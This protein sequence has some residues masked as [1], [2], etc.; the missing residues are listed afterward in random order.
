MPG[1]AVLHCRYPQA[2]T[3]KA[4]LDF[5]PLVCT[6]NMVAVVVFE[7]G[8]FAAWTLSYGLACC[9]HLSDTVQNVAAGTGSAGVWRLFALEAEG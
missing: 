6:F 7:V 2:R 3:R 8:Q 5:A 9:F 4:E 1:I